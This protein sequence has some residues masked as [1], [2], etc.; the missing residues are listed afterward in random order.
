[1]WAMRQMNR[2]RVLYGIDVCGGESLSMDPLSEIGAAHA[3]CI[4]LEVYIGVNTRKRSPAAASIH[5][6]VGV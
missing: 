3:E 1:M 4:H 2:H 6:L 5:Y